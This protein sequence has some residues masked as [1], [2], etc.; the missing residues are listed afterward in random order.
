MLAF[1]VGGHASLFSP[2]NGSFEPATAA[3]AKKVVVGG[4]RLS[5]RVNGKAV[6]RREGEREKHMHRNSIICAKLL[7]SCEAIHIGE[8]E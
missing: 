8:K 6:Y 1:F 4:V 3:A 7:F 5:S 2:S